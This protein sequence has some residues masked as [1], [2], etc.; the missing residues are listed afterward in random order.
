M[1]AIELNELFTQQQLNIAFQQFVS[2]GVVDP[3]DIEDLEGK[4]YQL[5]MQRLRESYGWM[6]KAQQKAE[7]KTE[8]L[9]AILEHEGIDPNKPCINSTTAYERLESHVFN[10]LDEIDEARIT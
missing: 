8:L 7:R 2:G 9:L 10:A 6:H 1:R 5:L 3:G 4:V